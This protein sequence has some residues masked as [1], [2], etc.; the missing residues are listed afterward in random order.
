M[1]FNTFV[2]ADKTARKLYQRCITATEAGLYDAAAFYMRKVLEVIA[3]SFIDR[4]D[5]IG[6]GEV[7]N[8]FLEHR[9]RTRKTMSLDDKIDFLLDQRH[10]WLRSSRQN[11]LMRIR[12]EIIWCWRKFFHD[13]GFMLMDSPILTGSNGEGNDGLFELDYFDQKAYLAQTGQLYAEASAMAFTASES[14][15]RTILLA[16]LRIRTSVLAPT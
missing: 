8:D 15:L 13:R 12:N 16:S 10:L 6:Q 7:F 5:E 4:Y 1:I 3:S 11:A 9:H 14:T 2:D